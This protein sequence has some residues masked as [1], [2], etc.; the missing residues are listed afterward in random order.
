VDDRLHGAAG[1]DVEDV[2]DQTLL[3]G[4]DEG[5]GVHDLH[6]AP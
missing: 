2:D 4:E 3:V 1:R 5:A 6:P